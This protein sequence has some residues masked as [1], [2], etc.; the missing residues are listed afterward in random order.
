MVSDAKGQTNGGEMVSL[1][2]FVAKF[3]DRVDSADEMRANKK[4]TCDQ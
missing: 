4:A 2:S 1:G 3:A